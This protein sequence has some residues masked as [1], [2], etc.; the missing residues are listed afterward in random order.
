MQPAP[1]RDP[2]TSGESAGSASLLVVNPS[3]NRSRANID[4][5]P[6]L[7]GRGADNNLVLRDNRI[8]RNHARI[9]PDAGDYVL[10]DLNSRHGVFVNGERV[11]RHK[12]S[13]ADQVDF[14]FPDSYR[15]TFER[16]D[17]GIGRLLDQIGSQSGTIPGAKGNLAK[18]RALVEVARALQS[19]LSTEDVLVS[20]VDAALAVTGCERGFLLLRNSSELDVA[21]ARDNRG[22]PLAKSDL[23]V[24]RSVIQRALG[25]RRELLSM[26][27]DPAQISGIR[28]ETTIAALELRSVVCVPLVHVRTG[29]VE[30]TILSSTMSDTVGVLYMDSRASAA[31]LS[32]G[33][34]ELL[35]TLALEASTILENARLLEGE[36]DKQ[37]IEEELNVARGIQRDLLPRELPATGW[38]RVTG[39]SIPSQQVGGDYFDIRKIGE[40]AWAAVVA[41]VSGK[42]VSSA[43]LAALLQGAFLLASDGP[44]DIADMMQ[45]INRF[46]NERTQGEKYA[47][48]FYCTIDRSG[49]MNWANAGHCAPF[50]VQR[51]GRIRALQTTGLPLGMM[52]GATYQ[53]EQT[54]LKPGD[55]LALYSDGLTE[56]ENAESAFFDTQRLREVLRAHAGAGSAEMHAA[57]LSALEAFTEGGVISDD[58][59]AVVIEYCPE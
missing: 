47:T 50:L 17:H 11:K 52:E 42:G 5:L 38:F 6:F 7:I 16:E 34:R 57:I 30:E 13:N 29:N 54:L 14:G 22:S 2:G 25:Q 23:R 4:A 31:D 36:R 58:I 18:L 46:L 15:L 44:I 21:V 32:A 33:N 27:F 12:L 53:V 45:R 49:L 24:P 39:S 10:E 3:G 9:V 59:T 40:T 8:S 19:S 35:Q 37:R 48:F 1:V 56:S 51:D 26:T 41:D 55:K 20:V 43:L 28:P